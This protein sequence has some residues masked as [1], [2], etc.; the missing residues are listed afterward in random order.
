[1]PFFS[2]LAV[3]CKVLIVVLPIA[4]WNIIR[5]LPRVWIQKYA[6]KTALAN[7]LIRAAM[8]HLPARQF[9]ALLPPTLDCYRSWIQRV[10]TKKGYEER[11]QSTDNNNAN[12]LWLT[13]GS[14][15]DKVVLFFHGE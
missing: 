4:V 6:L 7:S 14:K 9:Q 1:M 11:V 12:I 15:H 8:T 2:R 10:G 13:K 3:V 5:M